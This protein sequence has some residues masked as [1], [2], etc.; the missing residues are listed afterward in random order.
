MFTGFKSNL[1]KLSGLALWVSIALLV[2]CGQPVPTPTPPS[3]PSVALLMGDQKRQELEARITASRIP[4]A[5]YSTWGQELIEKGFVARPPEGPVPSPKLSQ[6]F[7]CTNC[8]NTTR[9]DFNLPVQNPE[10]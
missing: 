10:A 3:N 7:T 2:A 5:T 1:L 6:F 9:E 4:W 8:H